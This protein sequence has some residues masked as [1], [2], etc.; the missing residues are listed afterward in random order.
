MGRFEEALR[1]YTAAIA[2]EP[3][4][5]NAYH[6][7]GAVYDKLGRLEDAIVSRATVYGMLAGRQAG[8]LLRPDGCPCFQA[9]T[10]VHSLPSAAYSLIASQADFTTAIGLDSANASSY[11]SRGLARDRLGA[12]D[13]ALAD[14]NEAVRLEPGNAAFWH[15][16][17]YCHRNRGDYERAVADYSESLRLDPGNVAALNNRGYAWRK[18]GNYEA[19]IVSVRQRDCETEGQTCRQIDT[20]QLGTFVAHVG[21]LHCHLC[22]SLFLCLCLCLRLCLCLAADCLSETQPPTQAAAAARQYYTTRE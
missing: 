4:N 8:W 2:V 10:P 11:N 1:D 6:N 14:F 15:S 9:A 3:R 5:A 7:R 16:R 21:Q 20:Q 22:L 17:G 12:R 13:D 18:L 19:A